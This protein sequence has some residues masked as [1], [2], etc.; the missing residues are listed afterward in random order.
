[1]YVSQAY[2]LD[3]KPFKVERALNPDKTYLYASIDDEICL[4]PSAA[5]SS[6]K[7]DF[8]RLSSFS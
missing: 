6:N 8:N 2:F 4:L 5:R 1:M 3:A 7:K